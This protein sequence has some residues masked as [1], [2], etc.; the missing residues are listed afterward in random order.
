MCFVALYE[1]AFRKVYLN[2]GDRPPDLTW[3]SAQCAISTDEV[4]SWQW[5][6]P[7]SAGGIDKYLDKLLGVV[8][9]Q[10][11][12]AVLVVL[13]G[14]N[15]ATTE[16]LRPQHLYGA[17]LL[18]HF[19][20]PPSPL[21]PTM[22][23]FC[24]S[25]W[26][27]TSLYCLLSATSSPLQIGLFAADA[28]AVS[29]CPGPRRVRRPCSPSPPPPLSRPPPSQLVPGVVLPP[30]PT[31]CDATADIKTVREKTRAWTTRATAT[32]KKR[33]EEKNKRRTRSRHSANKHDKV[34]DHCAEL[35]RFGG[36]QRGSRAPQL[37]V[38][39]CV[40]CGCGWGEGV[41]AKHSG[42][43]VARGGIEE[44]TTMPFFR[45]APGARLAAGET[46]QH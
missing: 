15:A 27:S 21:I 25:R 16:I 30:S 1:H 23:T 4:M 7:C 22:Q 18:S 35:F 41:A 11:D 29:A 32:G 14:D 43:R 38:L 6:T 36:S 45:S 26:F 8:G 28:G 33:K 37:I 19:Y 9:G 34:L 5:S 31:P 17:W 13:K 2:G 40:L 24:L 10:L 44:N 20:A 3:T 12:A 39:C 46:R 42:A